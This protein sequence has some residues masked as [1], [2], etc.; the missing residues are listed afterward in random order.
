MI[1]YLFIYFSMS[2]GNGI[3]LAMI[4][5][6]VQM[7]ELYTNFVYLTTLYK[8]STWTCVME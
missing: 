1:M 3:K 5:E 7:I 6:L 2:E 4:L 8:D